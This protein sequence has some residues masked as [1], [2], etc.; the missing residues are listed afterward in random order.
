MT[1][2]PTARVLAVLELLQNYGT[3][4]APELAKRLEVDARTIRRYITTLQ[5]MGIPVE[6]EYGRDGGY[7]LRRGYKLPPLMFNHEEVLALAI[8]LSL[9]RQSGLNRIVSTSESVLAK[10]E[11]V[12]PENLADQL[13]AIREAA[14]MEDDQAAIEQ[15]NAVVDSAVLATFSLAAQ[16]HQQL[17][18]SYGSADDATERLIDVY[19]VV[20]QGRY[21]YAV[22]YCHLRA[23]L[24][25]FRLDRVTSVSAHDTTFT[26]PAD[27]DPQAYLFA[28][29]A[30]IPDEWGVDVLLHT[31]LKKAQAY[32]PRGLATLSQE[33]D[34]IHL[35]AAIRDLDD[36]ALM[37]IRLG[38][39]VEVITPPEL[40]DAMRT[41]AN[42]V[43][44]M[45]P[46]QP[47]G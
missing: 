30:A 20:N 41:V 2:R 4:N 28:S 36:M 44:A 19:G 11:R 31:T 26:P 8:G 18:I 14:Q 38:C 40:N 47:S 21:W 16:R 12:L 35:R 17:T 13:R 9:V 1:Y 34:H 37:L 29:I 46:D 42:R 15:S 23:G 32:I 33:N 27:F 39:R 6:A 7:S 5:D 45:L 3:L 25:N 22:T 43:Y 10:I 24:R